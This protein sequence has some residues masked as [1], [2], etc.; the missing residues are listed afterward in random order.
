MKVSDLIALPFQWGSAIRGRRIFHPAGVLAKG[1]IERVAPGRYGLPIPS[2][3]AIARVSKASGTPGSLPDF[4]GLALRVVP[5]QAVALPW[6]ILL[7]S[8]GS[9]V[10]SRAVALRPT[11]SWTGQTLT[12]LMP[13]RYGERNWWLRARIVTDIDGFGLSLQSVRDGIQCGGIDIAI[14]QPRGAADF[15]PLARLTLTTVIEA[16][17]DGDV[18]FDPVVNT[19]PGLR[20]YPAWLAGLRARAYH[21][22]RTGRAAYSSRAGDRLRS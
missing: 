21:R 15:E 6:D 12:S 18:S 11:M 8:A 2:G 10:V 9:G 1:A 7:V 5:P 13:L 4:I 19:A 17:Q 14:D 22:S 20:L 16:E 3:D